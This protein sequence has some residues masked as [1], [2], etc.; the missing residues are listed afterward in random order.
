[1]IVGKRDVTTVPTQALYLMNNPFVLKQA[2]DM[3]HRVLDAKENTPA[4]RLELAFRLALG[5][6]PSE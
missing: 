3:A 4:A 2:Q 5:R 6:S 1:M